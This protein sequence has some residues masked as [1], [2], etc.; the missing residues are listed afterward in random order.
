MRVYISHPRLSLQ[1]QATRATEKEISHR[2]SKEKYACN[3]RNNEK[4]NRR[5][6]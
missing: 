4:K 5:T 3:N 1:L 2:N 6:Q